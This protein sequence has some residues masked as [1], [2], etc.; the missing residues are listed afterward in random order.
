MPTYII[1]ETIVLKRGE[2]LQGVIT[3]L[4]ADKDPRIREVPDERRNHSSEDRDA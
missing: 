1:S 2:T 4:L 3:R